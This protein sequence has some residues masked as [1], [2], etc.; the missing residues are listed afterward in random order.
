MVK[1]NPKEGKTEISGG[2]RIRGSTV[3]GSFII[4][5]PGYIKNLTRAEIIR[6]LE[7]K[8][9]VKVTQIK[10]IKYTYIVE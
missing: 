8:F 2:F 9:D 7:D 10:F 5:R 6:A 3:F 4:Y 1:R